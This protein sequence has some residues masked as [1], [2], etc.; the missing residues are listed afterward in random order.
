MNNLPDITDSKSV[1]YNDESVIGRTTPIK[2]FSYSENRTISMQI[3]LFV[4]SSGDLA[5]NLKTLRILESAAYTRSG[6]GGAPFIPPPVCKIECGRLLGDGGV[7]VVMKSYSVKFPPDV[8]WDE[9]TLLPFK[10]DVD[11]SWDVVYSSK[12]LPGQQNILKSGV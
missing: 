2:T 9:K 10:F 11:T 12:A 1:S 5:K 8:A 6:S 4:T 7:C 3:H